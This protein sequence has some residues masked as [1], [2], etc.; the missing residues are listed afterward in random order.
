[1]KEKLMSEII[2]KIEEFDTIAIYRHVFPDPDS[3]S[4]QTALKSIIENTY[5]NKKVV[6]LGEHSRNLEYINTMDEQIDLNENSLAIIVDVANKERVDNQS[7]NKCGY[8]L[9][10]DHHK[11]FDAPFED[12][13]WVD[14]DYSS[15]SEMILDLYLANSD[16]LK[17]DKKGRKAL[18]TGI[19]GDTG[20]FLYIEN[21]TNLFEKLSKVTFDLETKEIYA[22]MYRRE[23]K[24][25]KFLGYIYSNY[26]TTDN[27]MAYLKVNNEIAK[28]YGLEPIKAARMVNALQDT[29]GIINWHFFVEKEDG[30]IFCEF[31]S[32]GPRVND[33][34]SSFG[35]G[36][37][38][39]AAGAS[40]ANWG[41]VDEIIKAF[42]E[43]CR[44]FN[45]AKK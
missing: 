11:P 32:N 8:I 29:A 5:P 27:G 23:E 25:L 2:N 33:I 14:T 12:L 15:C 24:E 40:L 4:S 37:H 39:L 30:S 34:A 28:Q 22:N 38:F 10:I 6:L 9:K 3:Y 45:N 41:K 17:I 20:R 31:R 43:N 13:T 35:G 1:M 36:G 16:K 7:F 42:D 21:P 18:F 19:I 26:I 44:E